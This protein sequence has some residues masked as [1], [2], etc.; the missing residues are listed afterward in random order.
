MRAF[1]AR[2]LWGM[3]RQGM[4]DVHQKSGGAGCLA[5]SCAARRS[6]CCA[7]PQWWRARQSSASRCPQIILHTLSCTDRRSLCCAPAVVENVNV[8]RE[9]LPKLSG[10]YFITPSNESVARLVEDFQ[11]RPLY[12]TA[13]VF[14]SSPANPAVLAAIRACPGLTSRLGNLKEVLGRPVPVRWW[15]C[16]PLQASSLLTLHWTLMKEPLLCTRQWGM[17]EKAGEAHAPRSAPPIMRRACLQR[18]IMHDTPADCCHA[19]ATGKKCAA[20][21]VMSGFL[22][23]FWWLTTTMIHGPQRSSRDS[24]HPASMEP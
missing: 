10:V 14:F 17:L 22:V 24:V 23:D 8:K 20:T 21:H 6:L 13:H 4:P 19:A 18:A 3:R 5:L 15:R 11:E 9:P 7:P 1:K 2:L 16:H 12:K